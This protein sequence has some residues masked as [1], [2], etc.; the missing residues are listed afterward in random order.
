MVPDFLYVKV[1]IRD[2]PATAAPAVFAPIAKEEKKRKKQKQREKYMIHR[3]RPY[4]VQHTSLTCWA[5]LDG[6]PW[7]LQA[8]HLIVRPLPRSEASCSKRPRQVAAVGGL[9]NGPPGRK[10]GKVSS[11]NESS[12]ALIIPSCIVALQLV[13]RY[14]SPILGPWCPG[15]C[16]RPLTYSSEWRL[17][18]EHVRVLCPLY[19]PHAPRAQPA[20]ELLH[21]FIRVTYSMRPTP[22]LGMAGMLWLFL[23]SA[24]YAILIGLPTPL[25]PRA[26]CQVLRRHAVLGFTGAGQYPLQIQHFILALYYLPDFLVQ[27]G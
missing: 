3:S 19:R 5:G 21:L 11:P 26:S 6:R 12:Y 16:N 23:L 18:L 25:S 13:F 24:V 2:F 4:I 7:R 1:G 8:I 17:I 10:E 27:P 15:D 14:I 9:Q 20:W 22:G